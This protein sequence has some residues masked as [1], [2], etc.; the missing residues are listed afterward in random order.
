MLPL[1]GICFSSPD[2]GNE[3]QLK[4]MLETPLP[5]QTQAASSVR[6]EI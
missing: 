5:N 2:F 4:T 3:F 6:S 1:K